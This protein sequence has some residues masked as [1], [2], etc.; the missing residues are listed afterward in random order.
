MILGTPERRRAFSVLFG[1]CAQPLTR[2]VCRR[3][4]P[5][6]QNAQ[7]GIVAA[8]EVVKQAGDGVQADQPITGDPG[9]F[10]PFLYSAGEL[11]GLVDQ[12]R[13]LEAEERY[14]LAGR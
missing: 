2:Y 4:S 13:Q 3:S 7:Q 8:Y 10:V 5:A 14:G 12:R 11:G 1:R 6:R 9:P